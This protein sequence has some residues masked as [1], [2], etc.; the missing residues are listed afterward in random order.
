M[1][2]RVGDHA[3]DFS[4]EAHTGQRVVLAEFRGQR[5]V[6]LYF[7]PKNDTA[8]CTREACTFR[9]HYAEFVQAGAVVLGVSSDSVES[10]KAFAGRHHVPF[11]LLA[12]TDGS[13]RRAYGV[14]RSLGILPGRVTYVIDKEGVVRHIFNSQLSAD[15]HVAEALDMVRQLAGS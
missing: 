12:D 8:V 13:L 11:L 2:I 4:L 9:D 3:P 1:S 14:A 5:V 6:V 15:R 10:H 7:Y